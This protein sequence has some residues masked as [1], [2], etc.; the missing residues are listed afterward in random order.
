MTS[1]RHFIQGAASTALA[2]TVARAAGYT[3]ERWNVFTK[4]PKGG[5]PLVVFLDA[6]GLSA[7][8][9]QR[10]GHDIN[11][12]E[13][14]F[15]FPKQSKPGPKQSKPGM[16]KARIFNR[17]SEMVFAGHPI[18]GAATAIWTNLPAAQRKPVMDIV[19]DVPIGPITVTM[20]KEGE[21]AY[22]EMLQTDPIFAETHEPEKI[23]RILRIP[24][25]GIVRE[26]PIQNV[27]TGRPNLI[28][29]VD[30]LRT[31]AAVNIDGTAMQ[32]YF[33]TGDQQ[34]GFYILCNSTV[35][36]SAQ[37]HARKPAAIAANEDPA[38]GSAAGPAIAWMV[39]YGLAPSGEKIAIEQGIEVHRPGRIIASA[40]RNGDKIT[41]VRIGGY[42]VRIE[43][44][45]MSPAR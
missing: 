33:A 4:D 40:V 12:S 30:S 39:R 15:L 14:M 32:T 31:A 16:V 28:V 36:R 17:T 35:D 27:S 21:T 7:D 5:N 26:Y 38:T 10:F 9:M 44:G 2:Q 1:R 6:D 22:G 43:Q 3:V 24:V 18:L 34:R 45:T 11:L 37:I 29:M 19:L 41:G 23:A 20:T 25:S 13:V 8:Q 42:S